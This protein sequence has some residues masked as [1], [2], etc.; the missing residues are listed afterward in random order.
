LSNRVGCAVRLPRR[1]L[2]AR[3]WPSYQGYVSLLRH[4][5][6]PEYSDSHLV[7]LLR[8]QRLDWLE[9]AVFVDRFHSQGHDFGSSRKTDIAQS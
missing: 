9:H 2:D 1:R 5:R 6:F 4:A 3:G 7:A 8:R